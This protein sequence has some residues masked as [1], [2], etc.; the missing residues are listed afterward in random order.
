[1]SL[2]DDQIN[3][4]IEIT[5]EIENIYNKIKKKRNNN[6][7]LKNNPFQKETENYY[8]IINIINND[9]NKNLYLL[10]KKEI[11]NESNINI[12][13]MLNNFI[14]NII[15]LNKD[16][17]KKLLYN[18]EIKANGL[19]ILELSNNENSKI[20][21]IYYTYI[22]KEVSETINKLL[23]NND[24]KEYKNDKEKLLYLESC[25]ITLNGDIR[26]KLIK[27]IK[28][29]ILPDKELIMYLSSYKSLNYEKINKILD[30][31]SDKEKILSKR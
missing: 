12:K 13:N 26:S 27:E 30:K 25:I 11:E 21:S 19:E 15:F 22:Y 10:T 7:K 28:E 4:L 24:Y 14:Y 8:K 23:S 2:D 31:Y 9:I 29:S 17:E 20:R 5:K 1:M 18:Q 6:Y 3:K 16:M